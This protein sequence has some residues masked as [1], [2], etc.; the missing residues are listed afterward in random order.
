M[1]PNLYSALGTHPFIPSASKLGA[2]ILCQRCPNE[3]AHAV[4]DWLASATLSQ[5]RTEEYELLPMTPEE[6]VQLENLPNGEPFEDINGIQR[7][8]R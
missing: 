5:L 7:G 6:M 1:R 2:P 3:A 8:G 4:H